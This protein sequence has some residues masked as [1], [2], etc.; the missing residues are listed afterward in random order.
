MR[1]GLADHEKGDYNARY[2]IGA[3]YG[4]STRGGS[5]EFST[6]RP[7]KSTFFLRLYR[8][9]TYCKPSYRGLA[10]NYAYIW[11]GG[12]GRA[13]RFACRANGGALE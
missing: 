6:A 1:D 10:T 4:S 8:L 7:E 5:S 2:G 13:P 11:E 3:K 12:C 9:G